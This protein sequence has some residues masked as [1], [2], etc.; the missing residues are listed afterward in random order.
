MKS[1][2]INC[3]HVK[4]NWYYVDA[5]GKILGRLCTQI[6]YYLRGKHKIEYTP[7][8]DVGD[9]II[10]LNAS[11]VIVT[12]NKKQDKLYYQHTGYIGGIKKISFHDMI[13]KY[14]E[15]V[16]E[17]AVRGMLPKGSLGRAMFRKLKVYASDSHMHTAQNPAFLNI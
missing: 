13:L 4:K 10:V 17:I 5:K 8:I 14:P 3:N 2:A 1:F 16:I 6:S 11:Q 7:N 9:Y 15:R 12:G